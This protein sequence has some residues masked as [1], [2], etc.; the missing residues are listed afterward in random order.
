MYKVSFNLTSMNNKK[1]SIINN[2]F[3]SGDINAVPAPFA[4][5]KFSGV[6]GDTFETKEKIEKKLNTKKQTPVD[7]FVAGVNNVVGNIKGSGSL[8]S[9]Y[10]RS[11]I[12]NINLVNKQ[13]DELSAELLTE[14]ESDNK[15]LKITAISLLGK[16]KEEKAID[17]MTELLSKNSTDPEI[18]AAIIS[19]LTSINDP[20]VIQPLIDILEDSNKNEGLRCLAAI[21]LG[22][23][24]N[25]R[26]S[27]PLFEVL[28]NQDDSPIVRSYVALSL[29]EFPT[30]RNTEQLVRSLSDSS[31]LVRANSVL[32]L[33]ILG[34]KDEMPKIISLLRDPDAS[35]KANAILTLGNLKAKEVVDDLIEAL[36]DTNTDVVVSIARALKHIGHKD[37]TQKLVDV[38]ENSNSPIILR[39]NAAACLQLIQDKKSIN[40]LNKVLADKNEDLLLRNYA[41]SA[42]IG[43]KAKDCLENLV[44][45]LNDSH[46]NFQLKVNAAAGI[47]ILGDQSCIPVLLQNAR[48]T[49]I[50][51]LK[52]NCVKAVRTITGTAAKKDTGNVNDLMLLL[53]DNDERVKAMIADT[54]GLLKANQAVD[55]L[56]SMAN[57]KDEKALARAY[58][59]TALGSIGDK[60]VADDLLNILKNDQDHRICSK[61]AI[62][63][64]NLGFKN[65]LFEIINSNSLNYSVKNHAA[66]VLITMGEKSRE[67]D[68]FLKP[69]LQV[70]KLHQN[71]I[72]G[73][74]ISVA[75]IDDT[76]DVDHPELEGRIIIEPLEH[77]GTLV[78]GN[79]GGNISGV[80][81]KVKVHS[82]N[83]FANKQVDQI[84]EKIVDQKINGENDIKVVNISLGFN[85]KLISDPQI[86]SIVE[87]FDQVAKMAKRLGIT[88]VVAAGND[89]RDIPTPGIGT[90][91]LLCLS[92]S[93]I[94]VGATNPNGTPDDPNDDS[95]AEFSS[96]P[97]PGSPRQLDVMAPGFEVT[98][99][100]VNGSYK[101]VDGTSFAT[102][103]V[104]G[105]VALMYQ[106][107]PN[108]KPEEVREILKS[109]ATKLDNE[110]PNMQGAGEVNPI[111]AVI[112]SLKLSNP[113]KA[114][115]LAI[116]LED[117][118]QMKIQFDK[119][120]KLT[121]VA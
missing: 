86:Q 63:L 97:D 87:R 107:N 4:M 121:L 104:S 7:N 91:N 69:G 50:A 46:E 58:A 20:K 19:A 51:D 41:L 31:E 2:P 43:I 95:R 85:S 21:S 30:I 71:D 105:L 38:I 33:G 65:K 81:P 109:T 34:Y 56:L 89:G 78:S 83:A 5:N 94:S 111:K 80:A 24:K 76:V 36:Q 12:D 113:Q 49:E 35:V 3:F 74:G 118:G 73:Q 9:S 45:I 52:L 32:A 60:K 114:E 108:I 70:K 98:L 25:R 119:N 117:H 26:A 112:A 103:F 120:G 96:Y 79:L 44:S 59:I 72:Q 1:E 18:S 67:L 28:R 90:L 11:V 37:T 84:L 40:T 6:N 77:H 68:N 42:L 61:A 62:S 13:H 110:P 48:T 14:L 55:K 57:N 93:V 53:D 29:S 106:V 39:R 100:Y 99:P 10:A 102:P 15:N 8:I 116:K 54:L 92:D 75:V 64:Y 115:E 23:L 17:Q 88:V 101:T 27:K 66:G 47:G 16:I 82:Y 22:K